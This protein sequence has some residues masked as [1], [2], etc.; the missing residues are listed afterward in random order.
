LVAI[1]VATTC[2]HA[3]AE[4]EG[5]PSDLTELSL[6]ELMNVEVTSVSKKPERRWEAPAALYVI[7][8]EDIR[9]SGVTSIP[10]AL[11][12][13]PGVHVARIDAN[14]W[15]VSIRGF[16][17]RFTNK[18]LV[19]MDGRSVY[20]PLF[21]G[22]Y[23]DVQDTMLED[24]ERIEVIRGPGGTLW[25]ANAVNGVINII[26]KN[27]RDTQGALVSAGGGNEE[28]GFGAGRYGG[29]IGNNFYYRAYAKYFERD[30]G[31]S[32]QYQAFDDWEMGRAGFRSDWTPDV[33]N[34]FTLQGDF[35]DGAAGQIVTRTRTRPPWGF[36]AE[37]K[38]GNVLGRWEHSFKDNSSATV[39]LYYDGTDRIEPV[40]HEIRNT[41][42]LDA[43][44]RFTLPWRQELVWGIE[45]RLSADDIEGDL[46]AVLDDSHNDQLF[47]FFVQDQISFAEDRLRF[48]FG[49]KFEHNDYSDF[50]FQPSA[51][52][53]WLPARAHSVWGAIS[54]AVRTPSRAGDEIV[55][56]LP[57]DPRAIGDRSDTSEKLT[58]FELGYRV[59]PAQ[60]VLLALSGF[61][62]L[63]DDL[64]SLE[65]GEPFTLPDGQ[66]VF[67]ISIRNDLSGDV[68]GFELTADWAL[69]D[70]W[71]L[72][73]SYSHLEMQLDPDDDS[74]DPI[75]I[76]AE[77]ASPHNQFS[78]RSFVDLPYRAEFDGVFRYVDNLPRRPPS[79]HV[80]SYLSLDLRLGY[81]LTDNLDLSV[82][83][84]NLLQ[85]HHREFR[86]LAQTSTIGGTEVERGVYGKVTWRY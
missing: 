27:A 17:G 85:G 63:Y 13:A 49:S 81:R 70:W 19:L 3:H 21:G 20:T 46:A 62:N 1:V 54:R 41:V 35:Y 6:E 67:P 58:A 72:H 47:G 24:I 50:E 59:Q 48:T 8:Q 73:A 12:L 2:P 38:G 86:E 25:G 56:T 80:S 33:R 64:V 60:S 61:Y 18:L 16:S 53:L 9:R 30:G 44:H 23:W 39:Q 40:F 51:R 34:T 31:F 69:L 75:S 22:V 45:Y 32:N 79:G 82:V 15:A 11:R 26:T 7:T 68:Y 74:Q 10:E 42:D 83:G 55:V 78:L 36:D 66:R 65:P 71:R 28:K 37:L 76:T 84:Q 4:T 52:L 57:L 29:K 77:D 43:Q 5:K 14:K